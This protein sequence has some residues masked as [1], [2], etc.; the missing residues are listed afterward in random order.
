MKEVMRSYCITV[1]LGNP[2]RHTFAVLLKARKRASVLWLTDR[3][4]LYA[5][6]MGVAALKLPPDNASL[7]RELCHIAEQYEGKMLT[8]RPTTEDMKRFIEENTGLLE[9]SYRIHLN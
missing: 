4:P 2:P 3:A 7:R 6:L 9:Q 1:L 8:L 5:K